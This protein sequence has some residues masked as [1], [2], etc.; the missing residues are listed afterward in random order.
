M[1]AFSFDVTLADFDQRVLAA[2]RHQPVLVDFWASWCAPCRSLKPILEKLADEMGGAFLLAKVDTEAEPD[3]A[4]RFGVRGIPD[5][6]AFVDGQ[7]VDGFTGALPEGAV[8]DFL[9]RLTPSPA[10][11]LLQAAVDRLNAE[12]LDGALEQLKAAVRTD[13][14]SET[15]WMLMIE[16]LIEAGQLDEARDV[17]GAVASKLSDA[18]RVE[19]LNTRLALAASGAGQ[20]DLGELESEVAA[21]PDNL[22]ARMRLADA[23][24]ARQQWDAGLAQLLE[25]VQRDRSFDDEAAR[26]KMVQMFALPELDPALMRRY[27]GALASALNC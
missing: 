7:M 8:R 9:K 1:S 24:L 16:V 23:L 17:L 19:A 12:D 3:L 20:A 11:P 13:P 18:S 21:H 15:A 25:I 27:R 22:A 14:D 10:D 4:A 26:K 2:S 5:V 6:R